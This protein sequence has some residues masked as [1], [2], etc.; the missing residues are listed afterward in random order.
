MRPVPTPSEAGNQSKKAIVVGAGP[1]GALTALALAKRGWTVEVY[2]GRPGQDM[3]VQ[4][5]GHCC[6]T[7]M[8]CQS[9]SFIRYTLALVQSDNSAALH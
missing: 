9:V 2:E 3:S 8:N 1:V 5:W 4:F 6:L 7:E